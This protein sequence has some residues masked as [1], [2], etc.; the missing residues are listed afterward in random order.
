[1]AD[2][3][4]RARARAAVFDGRAGVPGT[5]PVRGWRPDGAPMFVVSAWAGRDTSPTARAA[6][7]RNGSRGAWMAM[8]SHAGSHG[9]ARIPVSRGRPD[10]RGWR[11]LL[12][13]ASGI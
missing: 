13:D 4:L 5:R 12:H 11:R 1:M 7:G 9:R 6:A 8:D 2:S 3:G 10:A